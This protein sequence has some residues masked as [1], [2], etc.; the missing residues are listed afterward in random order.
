MNSITLSDEE[1]KEITRYS[2][3]DCQMRVLKQFGIPFIKRVDNSLGVLRKHC[4]TQVIEEINQPK[5]KSS[6]K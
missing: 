1:I 3:P 6:K 4:T 5:L 2:R